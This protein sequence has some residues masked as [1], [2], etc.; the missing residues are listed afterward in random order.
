[1]FADLHIHSALSACADDDMTPNNILNM[2]VLK[3]LNVIAICDHNSC[4]QQPAIAKASKGKPINV[5][6]GVEVTSSEEVHVL[7]YFNKLE[8]CMGFD[9]WLETILLP[10]ENNEKFFGKQLI[11]DENDEVIEQVSVCLSMATTA[12]LKQILAS[13]ES[14]GGKCVFAHAIGKSH[15]VIRQ[16]GFIPQDISI[17]GIEVTDPKH[18]VELMRTHPRFENTLWLYSSDAHQLIDINE[19]D[20]YIT[21]K[22]WKEFW[23]EQS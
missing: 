2:A 1:M 23:G 17:S 18:Q 8:D 12:T 19:K 5:V 20:F 7:C 6:Y 4:K 16:L 15:G 11:Y 13:A 9:R 22:Q 21:S 3:G 10:I 14:F